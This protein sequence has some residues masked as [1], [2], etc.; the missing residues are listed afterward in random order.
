MA[1]MNQEKKAIIKAALDQA[2][3][4]SGIKYSLKV[5]HWSS[6]TCTIKSAPIDFIAAFH[7]A[8][9]YALEKKYIQVNPYWFNDHFSIGA[10]AWIEKI[11]TALK[12]ANW[13]DKSD[14]MID[15]FD[16]AYYIHLNIGAWD[17]PFKHIP[18]APKKL[19]TMVLD[20]Y[21]DPGHGWVKIGL[22]K[23]AALGIAEDI[24]HYSYMRN[25]YAYL[26]EDCDLSLLYKACDMADIVLKLRP[27][28]CDNSSKIRNYDQYNYKKAVS[29]QE[30]FIKD[31]FSFVHIK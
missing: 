22:D 25:G 24:S 2:L 12:A 3:A 26:E 27:H 1:Y 18:A 31:H 10:A 15:Y 17:K 20:Y 19:K 14:A 30:K 21:Q 9:Q 6:I 13:Y 5:D 16:I 28:N 29:A 4:G 23:L 11:I 8:D 7:A